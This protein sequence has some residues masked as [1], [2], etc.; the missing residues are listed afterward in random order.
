MMTIRPEVKCVAGRGAKSDLHTIRSAAAG[1]ETGF[2]RRNIGKLGCV[3]CCVVEVDVIVQRTRLTR[4]T[5]NSFP[6]PLSLSSMSLWPMRI[7]MHNLQECGVFFCCSA[8][9]YCHTS[10]L[11]Q[12][13]HFAQ[14]LAIL[15]T[16]LAIHSHQFPDT[17]KSF[18]FVRST[19]SRSIKTERSVSYL[20]N[21]RRR[22]GNYIYD[23]YRKTRK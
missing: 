7:P 6:L 15:E 14:K 19:Y 23:I 9:R 18:L 16:S 21:R 3:F 20:H 1:A 11:L 5:P 10:S 8:P 17:C 22:C 13:T 2:D 4:L 12:E